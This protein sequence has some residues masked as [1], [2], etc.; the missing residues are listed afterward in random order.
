MGNFSEIGRM[1]RAGPPPQPTKKTGK[2]GPIM[3]GG[4]HNDLRGG[5]D[6]RGFE[7]SDLPEFSLVRTNARHGPP[8][9]R[10]SAQLYNRNVPRTTPRRETGRRQTLGAEVPS[11]GVDS[12]GSMPAAG[13]LCCPSSAWPRVQ[14]DAGLSKGSAFMGASERGPGLGVER[15]FLPQFVPRGRSARREGRAAFL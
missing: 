6:F 4:D 9:D 14:A 7:N 2:G 12:A 5:L 10:R 8:A 1:R 13:E 15:I 3:A 11:V